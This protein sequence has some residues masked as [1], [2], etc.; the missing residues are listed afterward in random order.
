MSVDLN[1][2]ICFNF[3][4]GW[5]EISSFYKDM[6]GNDVTPQNVYILELCDIKDKITMNQLSKGMDLDGS[7]VSTLVA[8]M[9]KKSLVKRTHGKEDRRTV[10]VQLTKEGEALRTQLRQ[11]T[12]LLTDCIRN[13]IS[14]EDVVK[15]QEMVTTIAKNR[16][17]LHTE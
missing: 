5:R 13:Q 2:F 10:F 17:K 4:K 8:R 11:K 16:E 9:E 6:L 3:Y 1:Q 7:A 12:G 15:L 14:D